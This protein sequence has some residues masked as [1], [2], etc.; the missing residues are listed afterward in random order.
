MDMDG[1]G[2]FAL[3]LSSGAIGI[4]L[5]MLAGFRLKLKNRLELERM[6]GESGESGESIDQLREEMH[7]IIDQQN[8]QIAELQERVDF[9]ERVLAKGDK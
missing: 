1:I 5:I 8:T 2:S 7:D 4:G 6:R 9:A 3:F